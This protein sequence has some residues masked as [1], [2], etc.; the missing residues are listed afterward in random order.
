MYAPMRT[1]L[2]QSAA[3]ETVFSAY[4]ELYPFTTFYIADLDAITDNN[5]QQTLIGSLIIAHPELTFWIDSGFQAKPG[6]YY[7]EHPNYYPVL[8]SEAY[9]NTNLSTLA[10]FDKNYIL[11][12]DFSATNPLGAEQ[13]FKRSELWPTDIIIMTLHRVGSLLGPDFQK[14]KTFSEQFPKHNFIAA[15]GI[16][17]S[18]D[19]CQLQ[20]IGIHTAL[21]ASALH[22]GAI[23]SEHIQNLS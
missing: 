1:P 23:N 10:N 18:Q 12:L 8:G 13:I 16:R 6:A 14:L 20:Q 11:S 2:C 17:N 9:S 22:S 3:I 4:L 15:G 5:P 19:L 7:Q 21:I